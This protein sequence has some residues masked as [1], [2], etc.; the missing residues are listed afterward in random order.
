M[1]V[2]RIVFIHFFARIYIITACQRRAIA[3][4]VRT[5]TMHKNTKNN[6]ASL[7]LSG[8]TKPGEAIRAVLLGHLNLDSNA[9]ATIEFQWYKKE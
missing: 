1:R 5:N 2:T 7:K 6:N 8:V 4:A 9:D 3:R